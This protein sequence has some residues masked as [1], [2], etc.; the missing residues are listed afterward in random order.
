M[1][2]FILVLS[3]LLIPSAHAI[4]ST[5]FEAINDNN[6]EKMTKNNTGKS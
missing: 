2:I 4:A 3:A 1:K 5:I 6:L